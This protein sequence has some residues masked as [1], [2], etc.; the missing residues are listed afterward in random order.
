MLTLDST[1][2]AV[3]TGGYCM[4]RCLGLIPTCELEEVLEPTIIPHPGFGK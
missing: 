4:E 3:S 2:V 1:H